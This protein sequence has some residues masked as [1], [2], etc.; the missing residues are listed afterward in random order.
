MEQPKLIPNTARCLAYGKQ[1]A[2]GKAR[3]RHLCYKCVKPGHVFKN[4]QASKAEIVGHLFCSKESGTYQ[5]NAVSGSQDLM[6]Y[7]VSDDDTEAVKV[8][9]V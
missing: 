1:E 5:V 3:E 9:Q 6:S 8:V 4:C 7:L 2:S